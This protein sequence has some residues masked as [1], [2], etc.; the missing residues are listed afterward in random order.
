LEHD[1]AAAT[2]MGGDDIIEKEGINVHHYTLQTINNG[3][4]SNLD[5]KTTTSVSTEEQQQQQEDSN[6]NDMH[7]EKNFINDGDG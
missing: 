3:K 4:S 7:N 5:S 2:D 1:D 6:E